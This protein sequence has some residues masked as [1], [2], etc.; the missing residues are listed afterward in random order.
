[1]EHV[2]LEMVES[3]RY[4]V[5]VKYFMWARRRLFSLDRPYEQTCTVISVA[6]VQIKTCNS[7]FIPKRIM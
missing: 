3:G 2:T 7:L 6:V 4:L 1:M 5:G